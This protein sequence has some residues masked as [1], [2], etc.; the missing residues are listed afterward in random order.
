MSDPQSGI[1]L[2]G[3]R[4]HHFLE[5]A[6]PPGTPGAT[7]AK[8]VAAARGQAGGG[9]ET[10]AAFGARLW[11]EIASGDMPEG[12]RAFAAIGSAGGP[13]APAT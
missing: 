8:A 7:I 12:L 13:L 11:G 1:F 4:H 10:V 9:T 6:L 3:R 2:E 5:Y